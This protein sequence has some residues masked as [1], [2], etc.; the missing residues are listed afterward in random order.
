MCWNIN[1]LRQYMEIKKSKFK[2]VIATYPRRKIVFSILI[3]F[4]PIFGGGLWYWNIYKK[5][6]IKNKLE[7]AVQEKSKG[8]YNINYSSLEIDEIAG[9]LSVS[10]MMLSYDSVKYLD[11]EKQG[12]TPS[13]LLNIFIPEINISGVKTPRALINHEIVGRKL[14][15]KNPVIN[16]KYTNEGKDFSKAAP[17]KEVYEQLLGNLHL[18]RADTIVVSGA[19]ITTMSHKT[20][21]PFVQIK[22]V[23]ITLVDVKVDSIS[24]ED[25]TR[26]LFSKKVSIGCGS[27][28]W[29]SPN[30][31]Y[32]Y[33]AD[34]IFISSVSKH[35][36][37]KTIKILPALS[38]DAFVKA[39]P[40]Q[41]DR[42]DFLLSDIEMRNI[43]MF[44]LLEEN[45]V[46]DSMLIGSARF[47]IYRD[48]IIPRD[49]KIRVGYYP[50]Q[51]LQKI[52]VSI[53]VGKIIASNS[54]IEYKERSRITR[55]SGKVQ[56]Y[57]VNAAIS[58]FTNDKEAI[59]VNHVM[60]A[61][62]SSTFLNKAPVKVN[63]VF[64]LLHPK[65]RFNVRGSVG[66]IDGP[67]L[68]PLIEP[69]GPA[70]IK[71]GKF[72]GV[73]FNLQGYDYGMDGTVNMI[74]KNLKVAV[75]RKDKNT[76]Q[77][78]KKGLISFVANIFLKNSNPQKNEDVRI[79]KVHLDRDVNH[80]IYFLAWKTLF[81]G[82]KEIAGFNN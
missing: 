37:V 21:K 35:L 38:E 13:V 51:V 79:A 52:P 16:I 65:G 20:N 26:M 77:M 64:Y 25:T 15:I 1:C 54:F 78:K 63:W 6:I 73:E 29:S 34:S 4:V 19:Q 43:N 66:A 81:K 71:E 33:I 68:N 40:V 56:F 5:S 2:N 7:R 14:E 72:N 44:R 61:D 76:K 50:H 57:N 27:L 32:K 59:A 8:L 69:M 31:L 75:L 9:D 23:I 58:N 70:H 28:F 24:N 48:L 46:A 42:F 3:L 17:S 82:I 60:T 10:N 12:K 22:D 39:L 18:I 67:S 53:N 45:L 80:S 55:K 11:F 41:D 36:S 49:K 74:Y 62:I 47:K 30:K